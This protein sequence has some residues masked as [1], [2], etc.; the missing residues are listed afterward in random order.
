MK[1]LVTTFVVI[2]IDMIKQHIANIKHI[3][4]ISLLFFTVKPHLYKSATLPISPHAL[5]AI[6]SPPK[7]APPPVIASKLPV[8]LKK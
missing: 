5:V 8:T 4:V 6:A 1:I 2:T 7:R 3:K